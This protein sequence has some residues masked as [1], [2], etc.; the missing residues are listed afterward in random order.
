MFVKL[1]W[2]LPT[3]VFQ[4]MAG[5]VA[6]RQLILLSNPTKQAAILASGGVTKVSLSQF[7]LSY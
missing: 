6:A 2:F 4:T 1:K 7:Y 5:V 3:T